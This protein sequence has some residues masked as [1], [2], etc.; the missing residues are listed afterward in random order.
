MS[1]KK[2]V[3]VENLV[4]SENGSLALLALGAVGLK[5][6][7]HKKEEAKANKQKQSESK[8]KR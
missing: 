2:K 3:N 1:D 5:A 4:I 6:W 8:P 7:R